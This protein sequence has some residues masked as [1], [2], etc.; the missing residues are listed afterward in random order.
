VYDIDTS[1][2][3]VSGEIFAAKKKKKNT[4]ESIKCEDV[5]RFLYGKGVVHYVHHEFVSRGQSVNGQ[6]YKEVMK[7]LREAEQRRRPERWR[8]K[9]RMLYHDNALAHTSLLVREFLVKHVTPEVIQLLYSQ[10]IALASFPV[11]RPRLKPTLKEC[12]FYV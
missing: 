10:Y 11:M 3:A 8:N 1:I 7:R 12:R 6:F 2:V 4:P 5:D 9:T